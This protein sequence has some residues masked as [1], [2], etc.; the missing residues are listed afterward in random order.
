ML[1]LLLLTGCTGAAA[2]KWSKPGADEAATAQAY[3]DCAELTDTATKTA[4]DI[5]QDIAASRSADLQHASILR[6]QA[7]QT[8][9]VSRERAETILGSCMQAKGFTQGA[10]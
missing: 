2:N 9:D 3:R 8:Q 1:A 10:K 4:A 7:Q 5:D 6:A